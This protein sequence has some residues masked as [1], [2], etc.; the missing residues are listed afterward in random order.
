MDERRLHILLAE[1][2]P[3]DALLVERALAEA[4]SV[5]FTVERAD[6]L[7]KTI[8]RLNQGNFEAVLLDLG[9]PDSQ[10]IDSL[11]QAR[12]HAS[13]TPMLVL[14]GLDDPTLGIEAVREGAADYLV[15][16]RVDGDSVE[17]AILHAIERHR[18]AAELTRRTQDLVASEARLRTVI[19]SN[20]DALLVVDQQKLIRFV[21]PAGETLLGRNRRELLGWDFDFPTTSDESTE[22][23]V[24][25]PDGERLVAAMRAVS[26]VWDGSPAML[27][28][29]RNITKRKQMEAE[30]EEAN[31]ELWRLHRDWR[32]IFEFLGQ[33]VMVLDSRHRVIAANQAAARVANRPPEAFA[34]RRCH[35]I[36]HAREQPCDKCP[37]AHAL[38][39]KTP[40][41]SEVVY[42]PLGRTFMVSC[43]PVLD[44]R[45][46]VEK[47]I[48]VAWDIT[49]RREAQESVRRLEGEFAAARRVQQNLF[50]EAAPQVE[51]FDIA[52]LAY[53][54][55]HTAGDYY[56]FIPMQDGRWGIVIGD[57]TSHGLGP[58]LL[59]ADTRALLRA[60]NTVT[61]DV[62]EL[63]RLANQLLCQDIGED[64]FVTLFFGALDPRTR[65]FQYASAGHQA[66]LLDPARGTTNLQATGI[67]LG[68]R[69]DTPV[70]CSPSLALEPGQIL[71]FLTDGV[72]E[73]APAN[74]SDDPFG[75]ARTLQVISTHGDR[76]ARVIAEAL[77]DIVIS[78]LRG[79][80]LSDDIT[81]VIAKVLP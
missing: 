38:T 10:G 50:P 9:L 8:D 76:P 55:E 14:T 56:D 68:V 47:I 37:M 2:N 60:F 41:V 11:I 45:G 6:N 25:H 69:P 81:I 18:L 78:H 77:R 42:E 4:R 33:P 24:V 39:T 12:A 26:I 23:Q 52:G 71:A 7:E 63:L 62:G 75:I 66:Y 16:G 3:G 29:L 51:G 1:G 36:F 79:E 44:E 53:P 67:P 70:A 27:V 59:M 49:E 46:E 80:P 34:E 13:D 21:N 74:S 58:A 20:V 28:S 5:H 17:R 32:N 31:K 30:L 65:S 54:A 72:Y 40:A 73:A 64:A 61:N 22:I 43:S 19:E 48:H 15:K 57:V 35:E